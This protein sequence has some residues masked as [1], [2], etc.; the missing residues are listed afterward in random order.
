MTV[1]RSRLHKYSKTFQEVKTLEDL[2]ADAQNLYELLV[3]LV[4]IKYQT[5]YGKNVNNNLLPAQINSVDDGMEGIN[6]RS[7]SDAE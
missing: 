6:Q 1:H 2:P 5:R 3:L 7:L 4:D